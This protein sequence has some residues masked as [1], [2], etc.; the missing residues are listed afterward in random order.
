MVRLQE[1]QESM[2]GS[3]LSN[4]SIELGPECFSDVPLLSARWPRTL[5]NPSCHMQWP[6]SRPEVISTAEISCLL[7][8]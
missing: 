5:H 4:P 7:G 3:C 8:F 1:C 6:G 2:V